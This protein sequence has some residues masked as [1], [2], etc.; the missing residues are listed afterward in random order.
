MRAHITRPRQLPL[1]LPVIL[2]RPHKR[3]YNKVLGL[4]A[5]PS[6]RAELAERTP[7]VQESDTLRIREVC[8]NE[9]GQFVSL[10]LRSSTKT[11][12]LGEK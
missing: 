1:P 9:V 11:K 5:P 2:R 10:Q 6:T 12:G 7:G 4:E 3:S 8:G